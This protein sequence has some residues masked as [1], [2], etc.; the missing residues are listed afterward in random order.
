M[1]KIVLSK[2]IKSEEHPFNV[3][4]NKFLVTSNLREDMVGSCI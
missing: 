3:T 1:K 2:A 4:K